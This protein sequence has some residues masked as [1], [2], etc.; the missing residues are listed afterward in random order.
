MDDGVLDQ[1]DNKDL[2]TGETVDADGCSDS[3][4]DTDGD[5]DTI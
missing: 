4:K 2:S 1:S 5:G 3:Q